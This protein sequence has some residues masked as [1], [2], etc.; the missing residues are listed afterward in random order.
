VACSHLWWFAA[1]P[2]EDPR[3]TDADALHAGRA[4]VLGLSPVLI[5]PGHGPAF[6]PDATTPR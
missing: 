6:T 4:R 2:P 3:G 5:V 1:G